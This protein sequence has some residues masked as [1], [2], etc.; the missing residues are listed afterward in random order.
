MAAINGRRVLWGA[1]AGGAIWTIWSMVVNL[2]VLVPHY[3]A[4][5]QSGAMRAHPRCLFFVGQWIV[6][7]LVL[8]YVCSSEIQSWCREIGH[9]TYYL[10]VCRE[11]G[12]TIFDLAVGGALSSD[13]IGG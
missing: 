9:E 7:L 11:Y 2:A 8:A 4:A 1:L 10:G 6:M 5:Q 12:I 3:A 13:K